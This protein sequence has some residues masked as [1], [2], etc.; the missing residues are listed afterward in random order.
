MENTF[1]VWHRNR[2][3]LK[4]LVNKFTLEQMNHVPEGFKNNLVWNLGHVLVVQQRLVYALSG[5][6]NYFDKETAD[7]YLPGTTPQMPVS[8]EELNHLIASIDLLYE[9]TVSDFE[10]GKFQQFH[11]YQTHTGF[12][13]PDWN[14]A[15]N[16]N[17]FHEG[18]H[19]GYML[20]MSHLL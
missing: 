4:G 16:F 6:P 12:Q 20:A 5:L 3:F 1:A 2:Q 13:I 10:A 18:V 8:Q 7:K 14:T 19:L 11:P 15:V 9:Q 17:N